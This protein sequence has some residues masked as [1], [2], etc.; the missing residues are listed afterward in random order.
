MLRYYRPAMLRILNRIDRI[1]ATSP[2]Y[3]VS[4]E[5]LRRVADRSQVIPLGI[6]QTAFQQVSP[7]AVARLQER[8]GDGPWVLFV[9][10]L[11]CHKGLRYL[12]DAMQH[13]P[14]RLLIVGQGPEEPAL[15]EQV[16]QLGL[17][18]RVIFAGAVSDAELPAYYRLAGLFCLP[19]SERSGLLAWCRWSSWPPDY[20]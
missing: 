4:S 15:R 13:I 2:N 6:D 17:Q 9:G 5:V 20:P 11:R 8:Y 19:A 16:A 1:I 18:D 7:E 3:L 12:I 14:A 10:V